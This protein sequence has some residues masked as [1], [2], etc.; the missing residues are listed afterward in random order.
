MSLFA[1]NQL[2]FPPQK[3]LTYISLCYQSAR[4]IQGELVTAFFQGRRGPKRSVVR[5][6]V[7]LLNTYTELSIQN[8]KHTVNNENRK[9][10]RVV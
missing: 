8:N 9:Q 5:V 6:H 10:Y 2:M 3:R 7:F 1:L 4:K